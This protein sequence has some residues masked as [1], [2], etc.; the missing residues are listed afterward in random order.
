MVKGAARGALPARAAERREMQWR[1]G[2]CRLT[3]EE[4]SYHQTARARHEHN[5]NETD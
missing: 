3:R 4:P 1:N 5:G 2:Q